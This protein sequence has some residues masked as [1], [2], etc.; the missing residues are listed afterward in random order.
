M[1][2]GSAN[3]KPRVH[4]RGS[5]GTGRSMVGLASGWV[6][7]VGHAPRRNSNYTV[8]SRLLSLQRHKGVFV[9]TRIHA[10]ARV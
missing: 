2:V 10:H 1:C 7:V 5:S 3:Q 6:S 4:V 9:H 8:F